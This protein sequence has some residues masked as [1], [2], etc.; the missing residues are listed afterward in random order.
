MAAYKGRDALLEVAAI[1]SG[2]VGTYRKVGGVTD[3]SYD[4]S[5]E[6]EEVDDLLYQ[7]Y[8]VA[9]DIDSG[10][11]SYTNEALPF[12]TVSISFNGY[13][14]DSLGE[15]IVRDAEAAGVVIHARLTFAD[16]TGLNGDCIIDS[17]SRTNSFEGA[18]SFSA[19]I[20][21]VSSLNTF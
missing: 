12:Q 18:D 4:K 5:N 10:S 2:V 8:P 3:I 13:F 6:L 11:P 20:R 1:S 16:T 17:Y 9:P 19:S 15:Q 21:F 14:K 7:T